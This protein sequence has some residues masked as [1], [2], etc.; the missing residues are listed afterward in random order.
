MSKCKHKLMELNHYPIRGKIYI[1][2][3][4]LGCGKTWRDNGDRFLRINYPKLQPISLTDE[5]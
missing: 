2:S 3:R 5:S 4:C 1:Y